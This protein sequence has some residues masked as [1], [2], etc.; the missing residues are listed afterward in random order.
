[1]R[2][3]GF[4]ENVSVGA[5]RA[6]AEKKLKQLRK[7]NPNLNPVTITGRLLATDWWGKSW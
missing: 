5:R 2:Y 6:K 3:Y 4:S 1:M 7:T